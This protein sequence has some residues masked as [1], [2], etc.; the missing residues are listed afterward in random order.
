MDGFAVNYASIKSHSDLSDL[1]NDDHT[2][3]FKAD[4]TR[5]ITG[6]TLFDLSTWN[7][8]AGISG[9]Q[10]DAVKIDYTYD[11]SGTFS[12]NMAAIRIE[13]VLG[14]ALGGTFAGA[15]YKAIST[16]QTHDTGAL[17]YFMGSHVSMYRSE[18]AGSIDQGWFGEN[19]YMY[20]G[21]TGSAD[22]GHVVNQYSVIHVADG[23][24]TYDSIFGH[25]VYI[26][27][28]AAHTAT[29]W[30]YYSSIGAHAGTTYAW[31]STRGRFSIGNGSIS[32]TNNEAAQPVI[33]AIGASGQTESIVLIEKNDGTDLMT[34]DPIGK[35]KH[36]IAM[37]GV[38]WD[39]IQANTP[40]AIHNVITL[41]QNVASSVS[42]AYGVS[43]GIYDEIT[44][45]SNST[46]YSIYGH[47]TAMTLAGNLTNAYGAN[48]YVDVAATGIATDVAALYGYAYHHG[49]NLLTYLEGME[50]FTYSEGPTTG[51]WGIYVAADNRG[52]TADLWGGAFYADNR[53]VISGSM[54]G[55]R[56]GAA[57]LSGSVPNLYGLYVTVSGTGSTE[58]YAIYTNTGLHKFGGSLDVTNHAAAKVA[59]KITLHASQSASALDILTS[60][61]SSLFS[62]GSTGKIIQTVSMPASL[63]EQTY[64]DYRSITLAT[65]AASSTPT[66]Y[67]NSIGL[68]FNLT[69]PSG[70]TIRAIYSTN[71][72]ILMGG[73]FRFAYG[74]SVYVEKSAT[75]GTTS[76]GLSSS[77]L[78]TYQLSAFSSGFTSGQEIYTYVSGPSS[79]HHGQY[80]YVDNR[81]ATGLVNG[82]FVSANNR[83]SAITNGL[84]GAYI[85][86]VLTSGSAAAIYGVDI[87]ISGTAATKYALRTQGGNV[88][89]NGNLDLV[90]AANWSTSGYGLRHTFTPNATAGSLTFTGAEFNVRSAPASTI[91]LTA[92]YGVNSLMTNQATGG[93]TITTM[94]AYNAVLNNNA[95]NTVTS[96]YGLRISDLFNSGTITNTYGVYIG[97][98]TTGTQTNTAYSIYTAD[99]NAINFFSGVTQ[100]VNSGVNGTYGDA[101]YFANTSFPTSYRH[102]IRASQS[103][104]LSQSLLKF[105]LSSGVSTDVD[106]MVLTAQGYVGI[107]AATPITTLHAITAD[108][109]TNS[110][111]NVLVLG[112][113]S[114]GTPAS[115]FGTGLYFQGKSSTTVDRDMGGIHA[116]WTN[117]TDASR[118]SSM[119]ATIV[120]AGVETQVLTIGSSGLPTLQVGTTKAFY[121]LPNYA[122]NNEL[123]SGPLIGSLTSSD[124]S[125]FPSIAAPGTQ[126]M[127]FGYWNGTGR[128]AIEISNVASG[129]GKLLLMKSGGYV[130]IGVA[131][132]TAR[133]DIAETASTAVGLSASRV[134][135][136]VNNS[137]AALTFINSEHI[138]AV[139]AGVT[140]GITAMY[141]VSSSVS[142]PTTAGITITGMAAYRGVMAVSA[143]NTV[144]NAYGLFIDALTN[145]GTITNTY[146]IYVGDITTGT[147]TNT[148]FNIYASDNNARNFLA[149]KTVI[150]TTSASSFGPTLSVG[151]DTSYNGGFNVRE[152]GTRMAMFG[153]VFEF[154]KG[155][156][157]TWT[158]QGIRVD[159]ANRA[160]NFI[161][162]ASITGDD[163]A[164]TIDTSNNATL[165]TGPTSGAKDFTRLALNASFIPTSGTATIAFMRLI[166]NVNQ[167]GGASGISRGLWINSV[168]TAA[169][170]WRSL[171]ITPNVGYAIY[172]SGAT[173]KNYLNGLSGF[174]ITGASARVHLG[175]G[176]ATASTAP[177]KF[178]TGTNLTA[179]EAGVMEFSSSLLY[180]SPSASR[181][182]VQ[183]N[184]YV[185]KT[186]NYTI[187]NDDYVIDCTTNSF[188]VTLPTAVGITG[189]V[190]I[191]KNSTAAD[192]ITL[193]TTSS[194]TIDNTT[195]GTV[196][197]GAVIRLQSTGANWIII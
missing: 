135:H 150:G 75:S 76:N 149:G 171:E 180:F 128:S 67:M 63:T 61:A 82:L 66:D 11:T 182:L 166:G 69:Q 194:Q 146:G 49:V 183:L 94:A 122:G 32:V 103:A 28:R 74:N 159:G 86:S 138:T 169:A 100:F 42:A 154:T 24:S 33:R 191:V 3:Y 53:A 5:T 109:A 139:T 181:Y 110:V 145:G 9:T 168:I 144:T 31:Q 195:P 80:I 176:T 29:V 136:T 14:N 112:H 132:P 143:L 26:T 104:T 131:A 127:V 97:D 89:F 118:T 44:Q 192:T 55:L 158:G 147:Q 106:V 160:F 148:A 114:S 167:T 197:A 40:K 120:S 15:T 140:L 107:G 73:N 79:S 184:G 93:I 58:T 68:S 142:N 2:Q 7:V 71:A 115:G 37:P 35:V 163:F 95:L 121:V 70:S 64:A 10:K 105:S 25:E 60:G 113:N 77:Q 8:G 99:V 65:N 196:A 185:A 187:T 27:P 178:T 152:V 179:V 38:I 125:F 85:E 96:A 83:T 59:H 186:A 123:P 17:R 161:L 30:G 46:I 101:I 36:T 126:K 173:A 91:G 45:P 57:Q 133:L 13:S 157:P 137:A 4:G 119:R 20:D 41:P 151:E 12:G 23:N 189:K 102:V 175:A 130:G 72:V 1:L 54:Y 43:R 108:T 129:D 50:F 174:G 39:G 78:S 34:I 188:T 18:G 47:Q 88:L 98:I 111:T 165:F 156:G 6:A 56:V 141:G 84:T 22:L 90:D 116:Y 177:L 51:H 172:Q 164:F 124:F 21:S 52:A 62:V 155:A 48:Y 134:I 19:R 117:E 190:F 81:G 162:S 153:D 87:Y 92:L 170:D 16:D 193:A